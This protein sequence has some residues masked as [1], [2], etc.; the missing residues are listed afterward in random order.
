MRSNEI[1]CD[2]DRGHEMRTSPDA[3][4]DIGLSSAISAKS[5]SQSQSIAQPAYPSYPDNNIDNSNPHNDEIIQT[6]DKPGTELSSAN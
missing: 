4:S 3:E 2:E 6:D 5:E 1:K